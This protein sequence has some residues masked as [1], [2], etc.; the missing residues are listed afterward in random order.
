[1]H[2]FVAG[3]TGVL[4][5]AVIPRLLEAGH[6]ITGLARSPE[7][8]LLVDKLGATAVRGDI[9]EGDG[10]SRLL[11]ERRPDVVVNLATAIPLRLKIDPQDWALNDRIRTTGTL[12]LT[13]ACEAAGVG[14]LVQESVGYICASRGAGWISEDSP[15]ST[16]PFLKATVEMEDIVRAAKTP[17]VLLR[18]GALMS[19]ES[20]HTQQSVAALR[21]GM[22]PIIGDGSAYL[23]LIHVE[24]VAS[25][26]VHVVGNPDAAAG[27]TYNVVDEAP[28]TMA[29]VFP[30]T[31]R[32]LGAP[33]PKSIPP[34]LAK[35]AIG[36]LTLDILIASYRMDGA[37]IRAELGFVPR[38]P[39]YRE[40]W[41]Q[42]AAA[43]ADREISISDDLKFG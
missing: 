15:R 29:E 27:N 16:H 10:I 6:A 40:T 22:L 7:K 9:L 25:A 34:F 32:L 28:A 13:R 5:R 31:A 23:S 26:I 43:L 8:L 18:L 20:W 2:V 17:G 38:Y 11:L 41:D 14:L 35:L 42:I 21:R 33:K 19:P 37:K 30:Y 4:G 1:M 36:S 12:N 39:T 3:A 24:D